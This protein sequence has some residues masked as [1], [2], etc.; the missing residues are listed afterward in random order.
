MQD[1]KLEDQFE[2]AFKQD[3]PKLLIKF[4]KQDD[5]EHIAI[6]RLCPNILAAYKTKPLPQE[7]LEL[8]RMNERLVRMV[9]ADNPGLKVDLHDHMKRGSIGV[10]KAILSELDHQELKFFCI[11]RKVFNC[12]YPDN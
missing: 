12:N 5:I 8:F 10:V 3:Q 11:K 9:L 4:P 6:R 1:A 2:A 7:Y